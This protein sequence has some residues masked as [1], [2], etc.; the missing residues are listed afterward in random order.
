MARFLRLMAA[1]SRAFLSRFA[2]R[3]LPE[4]VRRAF[5]ADFRGRVGFEI[6]QFAHST[7]L[8]WA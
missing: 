4:L 5:D 1:R 2:A 3:G 6:V 7:C 8:D